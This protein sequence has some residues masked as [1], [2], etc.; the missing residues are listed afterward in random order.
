M[1]GEIQS[2]L[3]AG[4]IIKAI[5]SASSASTNGKSVK[6]KSGQISDLTEFSKTVLSNQCEPTESHH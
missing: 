3:S 5:F 4:S 2:F 6:I 1:K